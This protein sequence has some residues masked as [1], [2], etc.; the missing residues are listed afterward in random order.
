MLLH[1]SM[2]IVKFKVLI[3]DGVENKSMLENQKK[4]NRNLNLKKVIKL[5]N[6]IQLSFRGNNLLK[7][8]YP[9]I[10]HSSNS[11]HSF[12]VSVCFKHQCLLQEQRRQSQL[13]QRS[14][15]G[16]KMSSFTTRSLQVVES[17]VFL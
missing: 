13:S 14:L 8:T 1:L 11:M 17:L 12:L 7:Q 10:C 2:T 15:D 3:M 5:G 4:C 9:S 16:E 6:Q